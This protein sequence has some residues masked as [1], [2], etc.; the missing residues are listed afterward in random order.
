MRQIRRLLDLRLVEDHRDLD[1]RCRNH[2]DV[3]AA[4]AQGLEEFRGDAGV[5]GQIKLDLVYMK[6]YF[7]PNG[8]YFCCHR[9]C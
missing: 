8:T 3:D 6:L 2:L 1:L 4:L 9:L 5:I 7:V